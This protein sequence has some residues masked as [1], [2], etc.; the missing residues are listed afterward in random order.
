MGKEF[1]FEVFKAKALEQMYAGVPLT[2]KDGVLAP[3]LENLLNAALEGERDSHL[4]PAARDFGNRRNGHIPKQVQ[5]SV[6][7]ITINTPRDR[8]SSFDPQIVRKRTHPSRLT[9]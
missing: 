4:S 1:D 9:C 3:L 2:G 5:S 8:D 6:G 7:E